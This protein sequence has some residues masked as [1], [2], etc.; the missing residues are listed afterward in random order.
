MLLLM[1]P[2]LLSLTVH[3]YAHARTALA[4]GDTTARD[5][6]RVTLNPLAHLDPIGTIV[7]I[8]TRFIGWARPV[9]VN[10]ANLHP[11]RIGDITVS[12][13][14][15][16]SNLVLAVVCALGLHALYAAVGP[17]ET[18][19]VKTAYALVG[20][21]MLANLGLCAFNLLPLFPLDGHHIVREVLP[22]SRHRGFMAWQVRYG[23]VALAVL[24]FAPHLIEAVTGRPVFKPIQWVLIHFAQAAAGVLR[25][26]E[27]IVRAII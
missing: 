18:H 23:G 21:T 3:E 19:T 10:P 16:L 15:P 12:L 6:G 22:A 17:P 2:L 9:P 24:V 4:F 5:Q 13:A 11:R 7:L 27:G 25:L 1:A 26:H 14:G 20:R 8:F